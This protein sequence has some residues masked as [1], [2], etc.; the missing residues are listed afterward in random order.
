MMR[1]FSADIKKC[2]RCMPERDG[3]GR[4]CRALNTLNVSNSLYLQEFIKLKLYELKGCTGTHVPSGA[5][6]PQVLFL[7]GCWTKAII[8]T[9]IMFA[10][11]FAASGGG[12]VVVKFPPKGGCM[13]MGM[14][15]KTRKWI[16]AALAVVL[17]LS[18]FICDTPGASA[19][20][21]STGTVNASGT[22]L[23]EQPTT[24]SAVLATMAKGVSVTVQG[25][26]S[27]GWLKVMYGTT[28]GYVRSDF[29]DVLVT[30]LSAPGVVITETALREQADTVSASLQT[31]NVDSQVTITGTYGSYYQLKAGSVT[32][33]APQNC[34]HKYNIMMVNL[35]AKLN[36]SN[37][38]LRSIPSTS[39]EVLAS[40]KGG[41]SV[42]VYSIQDH[43]VKI[44]YKEQI[45]YVRGD[46]LTYTM[47][48]GRYVTEIHPGMRGQAVTTLQV[49]LR[50]KGFFHTAANGVYGNATRAAV[51]K[52]QESVY[53]D[54]DGIAGTQ[55]L[56]LLFGSSDV[57]KL[58]NNYRSEMDAQSP[59]QSGRVW[60][61]DWFDGMEDICTRYEPFEVIDVRTGIHWNM[62]RF[63]GVTALW[64]ADVETMT[65]DDTAKM[66]QAWGGELNPTRR[67]VWV[68]IGGKYYAAS[69]MGFVHNTDTISTN[70]MDG[71]ICL[72]FRGSKIHSSGH[73]DEAH[74]ACI[75]EAFANAAKLDAYIDS[76]RV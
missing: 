45:G 53:L 57:G 8:G 40:M 61:V 9:S 33:F 26:E 52:F 19:A 15:F 2:I 67:P 44:K 36:S 29:I 48:S 55:T 50:K 11:F 69:L 66:T 74:Q 70:G 75:M 12:F 60:L 58:W 18:A 25:D 22:N 31:L 39:G 49:A 10:G 35:S 59:Q 46:F 32:G 37:V 6:M 28:T 14:G 24:A 56:L 51:K 42:T 73:I 16:S 20:T 3:Y 27:D 72:H 30:G 23:R 43:W 7:T 63:G 47:P 71:Q 76:G 5:S 13:G 62:Q 34:V 65:K 68:K 17:V 38:N 54:A 1:D 64:H 4:N 41:T 21:G